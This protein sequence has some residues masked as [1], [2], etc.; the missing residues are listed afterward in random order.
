MANDPLSAYVAWVI[1]CDTIQVMVMDL[2]RVVCRLDP[3]YSTDSF[4]KAK[5]TRLGYETMLSRLHTLDPPPPLALAFPRGSHSATRDPRKK[6]NQVT[7]V[8]RRYLKQAHLRQGCTTQTK[9]GTKKKQ[10]TT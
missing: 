6:N 2:L 10:P 7:Q 1:Q 8:G 4:R 5:C 3:L 9:S